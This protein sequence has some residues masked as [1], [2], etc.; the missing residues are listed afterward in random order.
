MRTDGTSARAFR[1]RALHGLLAVLLLLATT[2]G[3][4]HPY[5]LEPHHGSHPCAVC[6]A[7]ANAGAAPLPATLTLLPT[8]RATLTRGANPAPWASLSTTAYRARGPP[9]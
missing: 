5:A 7:S 6:L 3:A 4:L 8:E 2:G 9:A 1:P